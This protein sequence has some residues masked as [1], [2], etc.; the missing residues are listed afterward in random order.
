MISQEAHADQYPCK[1]S[2]YYNIGKARVTD[3]GILENWKKAITSICCPRRQ[4]EES[5]ELPSLPLIPGKV[6][7]QQFQETISRYMKDRKVIV[8]SQHEFMKERSCLTNPVAT[9]DEMTSLEGK[10]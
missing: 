10:G 6:L 3:H 7:K 9:Y 8:S 1:G 5:G 2:L 4:K